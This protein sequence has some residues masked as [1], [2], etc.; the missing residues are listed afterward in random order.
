MTTAGP[1]APDVAASPDGDRAAEVIVIGAGHNGLV[2]A[3]YLARAGRD[4]L[5]L[6]ANPQIGGCTTTAAYIPAAPEHLISP[7]AA[8]FAFIRASTVVEDLRLRDFGYR[9]QEIDPPYVALAS[10]GSSLAMWRDAART[11]EEI[12]RFSRRD[13]DTY[14]RYARTLDIAMD[15]VLPMFVNHPT[16][17]SRD[18]VISALRTASRHPRAMAWLARAI[19]MPAADAIERYFEHALVRDLLCGCFAFVTPLTQRGSG[20]DFMFPGFVHRL[21]IGRP[22]GGTGML[23]AALARCLARHGGRIRTSAPVDELN[24]RAGQITGVRLHSGEQ[25]HADT[26][27][28]SCDPTSTLTR[29]LPASALSNRLTRRAHRIPTENGGVAHFKVDI[30]LAGQLTLSRHQANRTDDVDLR[31]PSIV[32][33]GLRAMRQALRQSQAGRIPDPMPTTSLIPTALDPTQAPSGQ[34]TLYAWSGWMPGTPPEGWNQLAPRAAEA[35]IN[36]LSAYYDNIRE[37]EIGR[38]V[39]SPLDISRRTHVTRGQ[40]WHVDLTLTRMGPLRPALGFAGYRTPIPGLFLTG[41]GT[42]PGPGVSGIPGQLAAQTILHSTRA[43]P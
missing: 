7:C 20:V 32:T 14:E 40:V 24:L 31:Q 33:G 41:G 37:L 18:V 6:E 29:L 34:D 27:L 42:H 17:P 16:R 8:D 36:A 30:A 9:E 21:G 12:R 43:T 4:V 19:A 39:E 10:D 15:I 26:V 5:V 22:I 2:A 35:T 1:V 23:P 38:L 11:A 13:A 3:C 25:L 28:A